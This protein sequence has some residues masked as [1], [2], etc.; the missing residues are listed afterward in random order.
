M[1]PYGV[2]DMRKTQK[3]CFGILD[4]VFPVGREGLREIVPTCFDCPEKGPCLKAALATREGLVLRGE[5]LERTP[6][7]GL[8]GRLKR[9]S[10]RKELGRL[11]KEKEGKR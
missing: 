3:D 7:R 5:A 6:A 2:N 8:V 9:W 1:R 4:K 10:E 11:M